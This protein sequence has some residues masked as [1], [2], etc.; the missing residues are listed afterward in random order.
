MRY[1]Q[2]TPL[3]STNSNNSMAA[4]VVDL[5]ND[6]DDFAG[7][8]KIYID[9]PPVSKPSVRHGRGRG[10]GGALRIFTDNEARREMTIVNGL[11][12]E[13]RKRHGF[14]RIPRQRPVY[15]KLW[16]FI[17]RPDDDFVGRIRGVGRLKA[18]ALS[19]EGTIVAIKPD[20][21]N[22]AKLMMDALKGVFYED[23]SQVVDLNIIKLRDS[24]GLCLG[25]IAVEVG[26]YR[27]IAA[28]LMPDF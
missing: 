27:N 21:D 3:S 7:P 28:D 6:D 9:R 12:E 14:Q 1:P 4:E 11:A 16:C 22:M 13:E 23:D 17:K 15:L 24:V 26:E 2:L 20:N 5:S 25:R 8:L 10:G 19:D 18:S